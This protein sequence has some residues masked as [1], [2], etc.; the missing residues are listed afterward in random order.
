MSSELIFV[1]TIANSA[2]GF[3]GSHAVLKLLEKGYRGRPRGHLKSG[4]AN[5][6]DQFEVA[7]I[8]DIHDQFP[9]A[10]VGVEASIHLA[11]P[12]PGCAAPAKLLAIAEEGTLNVIVQG[13]KAGVK[14]MV[15]TS[16]MATFLNS[17][18]SFTDEDLTV[19]N[20]LFHNG[21]FPSKPFDID[22]RDVA[23]AHVRTL[24]SPPTAQVGRKRTIISS[25]RSP[26]AVLALLHS[27]E[28]VV[29]DMDAK[30]NKGADF[31]KMHAFGQIPVLDDDGFILYEGRAI[32]RYLAE[33]Y[34][35]KG[36]PLL[37]NG[38]RERARVD[39]AAAR[40][41]P[42]NEIAT[43]NA[44]EAILG[45][46]KFLAGDELTPA[47]LFHLTSVPRLAQLGVDVIAGQGPN[48]TRW[49]ND[50]ISCSA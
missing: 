12:L 16:S 36:T 31:L 7:K 27:F 30:E 41:L 38:L 33:M 3:L 25:A 18:D 23:Q 45:K 8:A 19:Y 5:Q 4:Y 39:Q 50:V 48:V 1:G 11:S 40:G 6:G 35:D 2:S 29:V 28:L 14:R 43:L 20:Y 46:S 15:V 42:V 37:P 17:R 49:W 21:V 13:E 22:V 26:A 10:L 9:E 32:C 44:Y 24:N 34:A 47:D